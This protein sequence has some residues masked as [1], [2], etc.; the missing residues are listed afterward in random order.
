MS[1]LKK[2]NKKKQMYWAQDDK[3]LAALQPAYMSGFVNMLLVTYRDDISTHSS[4]EHNT[5]EL[6][7]ASVS[8]NSQL[9]TTTHH[10]LKVKVNY[11]NIFT[12]IFIPLIDSLPV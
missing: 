12:C 11:K 7:T 1:G 4:Q 6:Y 8:P 9:T 10:V 2:Q 3:M 5:A